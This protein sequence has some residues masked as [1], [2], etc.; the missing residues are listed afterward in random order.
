[1][2]F[3]SASFDWHQLLMG[4]EDWPFLGWVVFRS[5]VM[6]IVAL[7]SIRIIGKRGVMQGVFELVLIITLGS[8]AG[9]P[10]FYS[11]VGLLPAMTV[12]ATIVL[13]YK[14]INHLA[15]HNKTFEHAVEGNEQQ[16]VKDGKFIVANYKNATL[17][18]EELLSDL[19]LKNISQLGQVEYAYIE[20]S[21]DLS[22]FFY[23]DEK[24]KPGLPLLPHML[25]KAHTRINTP[26]LYSCNF[27][28][29]TIQL[30]PAE[31]FSCSECE[32]TEWVEASDA[33]RIT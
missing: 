16:L 22:V 19:R 7:V 4:E 23:P 28:G 31:K 18:K 11:K 25:D 12:F 3:D 30:Q 32:E 33:R 21:G 29:N 14:I 15:T 1:M 24:V 20:P 8:A 2:P 17:G 13:M 26:G 9:D 5:A 27:C 10:M 6:F